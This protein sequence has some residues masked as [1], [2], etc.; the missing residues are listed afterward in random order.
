MGT[1]GATSTFFLQRKLRPGKGA[2]F[3][4]NGVLPSLTPWAVSGS[5]FSSFSKVSGELFLE[6]RKGAAS[7][8]LGTG[9]LAS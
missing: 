2:W 1:H 6:V 5:F 8:P 3:L 7:G 9:V 4:L